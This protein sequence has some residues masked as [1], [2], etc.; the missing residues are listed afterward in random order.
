MAQS[1]ESE[2]A[3]WNLI[4][5]ISSISLL[6]FLRFEFLS[7]D[8]AEARVNLIGQSLYLLNPAIWARLGNWLTLSVHPPSPDFRF[9]TPACVLKMNLFVTVASERKLQLNVAPNDLILSSKEELQKREG[10]DVQ[11]QA[12]IYHGRLL[13]DAT[14]IE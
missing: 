5:D 8:A 7:V 9:V 12:I 1:T 4:S 11:R 6:E 14:T 3:L 13:G 10:I 2:N